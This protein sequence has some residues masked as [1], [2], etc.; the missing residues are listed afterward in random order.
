MIMEESESA[1]VPLVGLWEVMPVEFA[2]TD[3]VDLVCDQTLPESPQPCV[4]A[5]RTCHF[6]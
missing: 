3:E 4:S 2:P 5:Q 1:E 6:R